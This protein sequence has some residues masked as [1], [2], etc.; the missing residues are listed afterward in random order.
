M[1]GTPIKQEKIKVSTVD[2]NL[3]LRYALSRY[4]KFLGQE[5]YMQEGT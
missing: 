1:R 4:F 2:G 3:V 5:R